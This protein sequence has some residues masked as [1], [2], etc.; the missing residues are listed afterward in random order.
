VNVTTGS[1]KFA[2]NVWGETLCGKDLRKVT[3]TSLAPSTKHDDVTIEVKHRAPDAKTDTTNEA[4]FEVR[5]PA[6]L[7][8][9]GTDHLAK[10]AH[11]Y[12]SITS[13]RAFDNFGKPM[14]YIDVNE[15]FSIGTFE[16]SVSSEWKDGFAARTKGKDVT[17]GN[18][19]FRD[20][21]EVS[22]VGAPPASMTP[23]VSNPGSPLG[24]TRVGSFSHDWYVGG[25]TTGTGVHVSHHVGVFYTDHGEYTEFKSPP[26]A[27]KAPASKTPKAG[28]AP[29]KD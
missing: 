22:L 5:A 16:K 21:Y 7:D 15:D 3:V 20:Q 24:K 14:P 19:V 29:R 11:G 10:G 27:A 13:L 8:L 23:K 26:A 4:K 9:L 25:P 17:R 18:A 28:K 6:R 12:A 2:L 1:D